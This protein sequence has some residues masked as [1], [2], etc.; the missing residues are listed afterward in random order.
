MLLERAVWSLAKVA[1][2]WNVSLQLSG[3]TVNIK[4]MV[5]GWEAIA[6]QN[7]HVKRAN[8]PVESLPS[9]DIYKQQ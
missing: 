1:P 3:D 9:T 2:C 4:A 6:P 5:K 7:Y 8:K